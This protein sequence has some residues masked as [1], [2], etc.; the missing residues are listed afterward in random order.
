MREF[1]TAVVRAGE[2]GTGKELVTRAIHAESPRS[3]QPYITL[4]CSAIA[5]C[6][7]HAATQ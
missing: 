3:S 2:T 6:R 1:H 4:N 7:F 5:C